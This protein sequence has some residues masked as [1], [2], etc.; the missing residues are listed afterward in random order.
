MRKFAIGVAY[1][2][3]LAAS[4]SVAA[5]R[6]AVHRPAGRLAPLGYGRATGGAAIQ[7]APPPVA[8]E[9]PA[10]PNGLYSLSPPGASSCN[11][12][13]AVVQQSGCVH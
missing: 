5:E 13:V 10:S 6:A 3:C 9:R 11:T 12:N 2:L 8:I 4:A 1:A 7:T